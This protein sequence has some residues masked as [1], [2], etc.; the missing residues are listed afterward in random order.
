MS[1]LIDGHKVSKEVVKGEFSE[2]YN[3]GTYGSGDQEFSNMLM[4]M[5]TRGMVLVLLI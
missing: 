4:N 2:F 3:D 1:K 5:L